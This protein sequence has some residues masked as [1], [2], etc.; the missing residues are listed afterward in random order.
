MLEAGPS[1]R[2]CLTVVG[3]VRVV[4]LP[5]T[6]ARQTSC[7]PPVPTPLP[8][9]DSSGCRYLG[10][11]VHPS[12]EAATDMPFPGRPLPATQYRWTYGHRYI[13]V[14]ALAGWLRCGWPRAGA[15]NFLAPLFGNVR[16]IAWRQS[17]P[18]SRLVRV[19]PLPAHTATLRWPSWVLLP[20]AA[21][22][23]DNGEVAWGPA[24]LCPL[25]FSPP[26]LPHVFLPL[27]LPLA[28]FSLTC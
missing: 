2:S 23:R 25:A 15:S 21:A 22:S 4:P 7:R 8:P 16:S 3:G 19:S 24:R 17:L 27:S 11:V 12:H 5:C 10:A 26:L 6:V 28:R 18:P 9:T 1:R 14:G 20:S 13:L